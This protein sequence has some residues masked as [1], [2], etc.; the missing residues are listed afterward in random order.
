MRIIGCDLHPYQAGLPP[1]SVPWFIMP[2]RVS[3]D[4]LLVGKIP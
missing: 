1:T 4:R 3:S 2:M